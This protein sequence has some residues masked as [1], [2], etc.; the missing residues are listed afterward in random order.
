[1]QPL[2]FNAIYK[3]SARGSNPQSSQWQ[4][5]VLPIT[6]PDQNARLFRAVN[7]QLENQLRSG[8]TGIRTRNNRMQ[9][10]RDANFTI[11]PNATC[12]LASQANPLMADFVLR[13]GFEPVPYHRKWYVFTPSLTQ[14][15][16]IKAKDLIPPKSLFLTDLSDE[17]YRVLRHFYF[18][19]ARE[20]RTLI[21]R[22][23]V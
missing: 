14:Q 11:A 18:W 5:D 7:H 20:N 21:F 15:I 17:C 22:L 4:C 3:R 8:A 12:L 16:K 10:Y 13:T 1:M 19:A 2:H 23:E 9:I 6:P